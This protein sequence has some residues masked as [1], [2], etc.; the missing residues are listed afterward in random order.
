M[1]YIKLKRASGGNCLINCGQI[2][3]VVQLEKSAG[4]KVYIHDL[5]IEVTESMTYIENLILQ[6][7]TVAASMDTY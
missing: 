3:A 2:S 5:S 7:D 6:N 1:A 4:S